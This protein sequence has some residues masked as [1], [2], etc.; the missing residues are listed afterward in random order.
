MGYRCHH[1]LCTRCIYIYTMIFVLLWRAPFFTKNKFTV[2]GHT[3]TAFF[4][5]GYFIPLPAS[6]YEGTRYD[7]WYTATAPHSFTRTA[8]RA[9][10]RATMAKYAFLLAGGY[11][12]NLNGKWLHCA[13]PSFVIIGTIIHPQFPSPDKNLSGGKNHQYVRNSVVVVLLDAYI[14]E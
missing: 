5:T 2:T 4:S 7:T 6:Y 12:A 1:S 10:L 14:A 13:Q 8:A 11:R 9:W 3:T